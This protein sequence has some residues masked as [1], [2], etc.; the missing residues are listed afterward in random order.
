MG[1]NNLT[2]LLM[3]CLA[4]FLV[5]AFAL[6]A[7]KF[8]LT[9]W[10]RLYTA[11]APEAERNELRQQINTH[12]DDEIRLH[13]QEGYHP[14]EAAAHILL[15][16]ISGI[17]GDIAWSLSYLP[18]A[19]A[20]KLEKGSQKIKTHGRPKVVIISVVLLAVMNI[21]AVVSDTEPLW[22]EL[23]I[24]NVAATGAIT[25]TR[26]HEKTWAKRLMTWGPCLV[27]TLM[28][29]FFAWTIIELRLYETPIFAQS[30][31]LCALGVLPIIL[32]IAVSTN[33][34]RARAFGGRWWPVLVAWVLIASISIIAA[35]QLELQMLLV[36]WSTTAIGLIAFVTMCVAF[37]AGATL[38]YIGATK[39][40]ARCMIWSANCIRRLTE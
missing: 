1:D 7:V 24:A 27:F 37:C 5:K 16:T 40:T 21:G 3:S 30:L 35:V 4:L 6:P 12:L 32:A 26:Y 22:R 19:V 17:P 20:S 9:N 2:T 11:V 34:C 23:L 29:G 38:A 15:S 18:S 33:T 14:A 31:L 39:G 25:L 36:V 13:S 8:L 28:F 10:T